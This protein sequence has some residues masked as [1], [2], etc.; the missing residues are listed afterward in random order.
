MHYLTLKYQCF[1]AIAGNV[2]CWDS[3][4]NLV[5]QWMHC[6]NNIRSH[7]G[8]CNKGLPPVP[9]A[10]LYDKTPGDHLAKLVSLG[11]VKLDDEWAIRLMGS[12]A[13]PGGPERDDAPEDADTDPNALPFAL[14]MQTKKPR[15]LQLDPDLREPG[16][17]A[18]GKPPRPDGDSGSL[19]VL[20]K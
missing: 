12:S 8:H 18:L 16:P 20:A 10:E 13:R 3:A 17:T 6:Y 2:Q 7:G 9:F 11:I 5:G 14:V 15:A 19:V 4:E 1:P